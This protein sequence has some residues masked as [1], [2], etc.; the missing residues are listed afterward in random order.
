MQKRYD[1]DS[2]SGAKLLRLFRKLL[3]S[4][5]KHTQ[6]ELAQYLNCSSQTIIRLISEIER[7]V[8]DN[9]E[10]GKTKNTRWYSL[11]PN[12]RNMLG[13]DSDELRCLSI[14]RDLAEPYLT[15]EDKK[16][17]DEVLLRISMML[18]D[19][20]NSTQKSTP[21]A[22]FSKGRIDY[23]PFM[24]QIY[25]LEQAIKNKKICKIR[26]RTP[27]HDDI[28][29]ISFAPSE[30]ICS[31]NALYILGAKIDE[32]LLKQ[33]KLISLAIHRIS[34]II[35]TDITV[36]FTVETADTGDF[37][38]PWETEVKEFEITVKKGR[39]S[40]YI[41]ERIWCKNQEIK[42]LSDGAIILK[43]KTRSSP[44]VF[45]WCRGFGDQLISVKV[46]GEIVE[47]LQS[48]FI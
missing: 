45:A 35:I 27:T 17:S 29:S 31:N 4:K 32:K 30:F 24:Y 41:K 12:T 40:N 46:N 37:G 22:F 10:T 14:C 38:L 42:E 6:S 43:F 8:G 19:V 39:A 28:Y 47:D 7:E 48:K 36:P 25:D 20:T 3:L 18:S 15:E 33:Q 34:S 44:E 21:Y 9:L 2:S 11:N 26:Y 23:S 16:R 1:E 13:L 5:G